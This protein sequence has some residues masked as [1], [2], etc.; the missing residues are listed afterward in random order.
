MLS[1]IATSLGCL[2]LAA[3]LTVLTMLL[4]MRSVISHSAWVLY[5]VP[6]L[7]GTI[8]GASVVALFGRSQESL[9]GA[10]LVGLPVAFASFVCI[11][12]AGG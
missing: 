10:V 1:R 12:F 7:V 2:I 3:E 5:L 6:M 8:A 11:G 4:V 9:I